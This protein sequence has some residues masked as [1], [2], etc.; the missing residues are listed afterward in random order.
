MIMNGIN[1]AVA[2]LPLFGVLSLKAASASA[3]KG[4]ELV[5]WE[6]CIGGAV[7]A[8]RA[9]RWS[10]LGR[11][12]AQRLEVGPEV[13]ADFKKLVGSLLIIVESHLPALGDGDVKQAHS[14][15]SIGARGVVKAGPM[16]NEVQFRMNVVEVPTRRH[17][18]SPT[19]K[20]SG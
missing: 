12:G 9:L 20:H 18:G 4:G 13:G 1:R 2:R 19:L 3:I 16:P 15:G 8:P 7:R 5:L 14:M 11:S 10:A 17:E 6:Q